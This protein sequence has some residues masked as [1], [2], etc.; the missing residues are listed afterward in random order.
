MSPVVGVFGDGGIVGRLRIPGVP[1]STSSSVLALM[2]TIEELA[3]RLDRVESILALHRLSAD[4]YRAD[5][6]RGERLLAV[7]Q[8]RRVTHARINSRRG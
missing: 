6:C 8:Y 1:A 5:Y 2:P 4:Y 7:E 3:A